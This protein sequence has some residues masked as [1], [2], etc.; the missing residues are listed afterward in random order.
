MRIKLDENLGSR[1]AALLREA[2]HDVATVADQ[3]LT[4]SSDRVLIETCR[5]EGRCLVSLDLDFSNPLLFEPWTFAGIAVLRPPA[6]ASSEDLLSLMRT[7]VAG[8]AARDISGKL[9]VVQR[10]RIREYQPEEG[11]D[12]E[13]GD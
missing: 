4:A 10:G 9:W 13:W 6:R 3:G 8:L 12:E 5:A 2:G 11:P 7:L 1:G